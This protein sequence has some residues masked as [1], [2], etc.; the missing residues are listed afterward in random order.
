MNSLIFKVC[1]KLNS[2]PCWVSHNADVIEAFGD[3][4]STTAMTMRIVK[5]SLSVANIFDY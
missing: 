4:P 3:P 2:P 5:L 1:K